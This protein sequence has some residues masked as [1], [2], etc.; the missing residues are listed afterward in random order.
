MIQSLIYIYYNIVIIC[1]Y[2]IVCHIYFLLFLIT[3]FS[4]NLSLIITL[5]IT[6]KV[7]KQIIIEIPQMSKGLC[8]RFETIL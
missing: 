3:H 8:Q 4:L 7:L 6:D 1:L 2:T 5:V